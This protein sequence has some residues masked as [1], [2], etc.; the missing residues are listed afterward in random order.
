MAE[1]LGY[2]WLT[3]PAGHRWKITGWNELIAFLEDEDGE[4]LGVGKSFLRN[5]LQGGAWKE[6]EF[7]VVD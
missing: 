5:G 7:E 6:A 4:Q 1:P 2:Q 3:D